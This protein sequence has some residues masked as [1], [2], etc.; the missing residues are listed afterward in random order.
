[1]RVEEIKTGKKMLEAFEI[2]RKVFVVEQNV[3]AEEEYD[4]FEKTCIH[5]L[6]LDGDRAIGTSRIRKTTNGTK[7]ERFAVLEDCRGT[8]VG[9]ALLTECLDRCKSESYVYLHAQ[10]PVIKFY[11]KYGFKAE[12]ERFYECEIPHFKMAIAQPKS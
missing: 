3:S 9:A 6:A 1:M 7:L 5:L 2:R 4:E 8:G 11:E 12:G 10:E